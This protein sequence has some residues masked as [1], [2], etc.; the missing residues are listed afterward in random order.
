VNADVNVDRLQT[1]T[2]SHPQLALAKT[3][4]EQEQQQERSS[5]TGEGE[6][7]NKIFICCDQ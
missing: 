6:G 7:G 5:T 3:A 1:E 4:A 2:I